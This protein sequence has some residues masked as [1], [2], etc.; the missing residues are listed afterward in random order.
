MLPRR[1]TCSAP[2]ART[3]VWSSD[4]FSPFRRRRGGDSQA[5]PSVRAGTPEPRPRDCGRRPRHVEESTLS[6]AETVR[7]E[8]SSADRSSDVDATRQLRAAVRDGAVRAA[9]AVGLGGIAVI[10][11][12]DGV[13][14]WS[15]TRCIF[16]MYMALI[17]AAVITAAGVLFSHS[18]RWLLAAAGLAATVFAGYVINRTFGLPQATDDIGNWTEPLGLASL[19]VEG[20]VIAIAVGGYVAASPG[21]VM[22]SRSRL[23][24]RG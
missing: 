6:A 1:R 13:G 10:H 22:G 3:A 18:P 14:K 21:I 11:A 16:W 5:L 8:H 17:A 23:D 24:A 12:V 20:F 7:R 15:D 19:L 2:A 9:T 4:T